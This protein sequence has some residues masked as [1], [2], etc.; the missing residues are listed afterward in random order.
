MSPGIAGALGVMQA[1]HEIKHHL[2]RHR[3]DHAARLS[4]VR[5][6]WEFCKF[7]IG[8]T[9]SRIGRLMVQLER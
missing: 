4:F 1:L 7:S 9:P 5:V 3:R 6:L 2:P 8:E